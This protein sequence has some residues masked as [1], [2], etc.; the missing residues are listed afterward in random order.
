LREKLENRFDRITLVNNR[1]TERLTIDTNLRFHNLVTGQ[2]CDLTGIAIIEL[3][4]DGLIDSPI[5]ALLQQLRIMPSG[6]SKYC[7]GSALTNP[8]LKRNLFKVR[9]R[10]VDRLL[11]QASC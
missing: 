1:K 2:N 6:F 8:Q 11:S 9:L 5:L 4:R 10:M 3:K 7:M